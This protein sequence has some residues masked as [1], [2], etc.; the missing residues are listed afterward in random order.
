MTKENLLLF[1]K[2]LNILYVEDDINTREAMN[3]MLNTIFN[4]VI[5]A[6]DGEDGL[7]K[8]TNSSYGKI[9][10]ILSDITMPKMDGIL[11]SKKIRKFDKDIPIVFLTA[12][13]D[14]SYFLKSIKLGID[15]YIVKPIQYKSFIKSINKVI[16]KL[17]LTKQNQEYKYN[18][19]SKVKNQTKELKCKSNELELRYYHDSLTGLKNRYALIRDIDKYINPKMM[20]LDINRFSTI[21]N[22]YGGKVGDMVLK[23]IANIL[24]NFK[25]KQ[26]IP[27]RISADQFAII[28]E[29]KDQNGRVKDDKYIQKIL[30]KITKKAIEI[31]VNDTLLDINLTATVGVV[32]N[33]ENSKLLEYADMTLKYA[34]K[35]YQPFVTYSPSLKIIKNYQK[36]LDALNLVKSALKEDR[37]IPFFQ[38]IVKADEITYE[39][40][41]RIIKDGEIISPFFFIDDIKHTP[42]YTE[43]T[44]TMIDKSFEYFK[45]KQNSFSINLSFEDILNTHI[46]DHIKQKL[47]TTQMNKQLIL[48]IL[49][50]ESIENFEI[51]KLFIKEMKSLG[52][53]IALDDF[54]SG[55]SNFTYLHELNPDYLK[56]DGSLIKDIH[57]NNKSHIIVKTIVSFAQELGIKTIAEFIHNEE[58]YKKI[59]DLNIDGHQG[60]FLGEPK[61][62]TTKEIESRKFPLSV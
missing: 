43:L 4:K 19:E 17:Y 18:L 29:Q 54:G 23:S 59:V 47:K 15:G 30:N 16:F 12:F 27:Y 42:Y 14:S 52:V 62:S 9:D 51:V 44:K 6:L 20:L 25:Y 40:L 37:L 45:D 50:S 22:I 34:K 21:N 53:R 36:A 55:Y 46:I 13:S 5:F 2:T 35:T 3:E 38:P 39:C 11:M 32:D 31:T 58:V 10:L 28:K 57:T 1:R 56:I 48:E 49:E 8:F 26:Y 33:I 24:D 41:V 61:G 7:E 60:Y